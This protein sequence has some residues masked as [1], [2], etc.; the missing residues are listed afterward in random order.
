[1]FVKVIDIGILGILLFR[2]N[3]KIFVL[4]FSC[5]ELDEVGINF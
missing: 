2:Y 5:I 1:M 3:V 4:G